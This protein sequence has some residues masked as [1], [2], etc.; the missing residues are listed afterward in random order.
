[1]A[2]KPELHELLKQH[3]EAVARLNR[4][5]ERCREHRDAGRMKQAKKDLD[6]AEALHASIAAMEAR[7]RRER[8]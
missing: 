6:E 4:L 3:M 1:M 5:L 7:L 2:K 8:K